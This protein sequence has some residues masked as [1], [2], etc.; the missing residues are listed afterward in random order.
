MIAKCWRQWID[1]EDYDRMFYFFFGKSVQFLIVLLE[2]FGVDDFHSYASS[3]VN[4]ASVVAKGPYRSSVDTPDWRYSASGISDRGDIE[5]VT[6]YLFISS[7][8]C[9]FAICEARL[10]DVSSIVDIFL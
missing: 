7:M 5:S 2:A 6:T 1:S 10:V 3:E 4:S 8:A 9:I